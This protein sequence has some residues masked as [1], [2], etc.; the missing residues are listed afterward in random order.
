MHPVSDIL[1]I[2]D[3]AATVRL[4]VEMLRGRGF[5]L[6]VAL[7]GKEGHTKV[8]ENEPDVILLDVCMPAMDGHHC[9]DC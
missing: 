1:I 5:K 6:R 8:L 3:D 9:A 2:D 4:L 7:N